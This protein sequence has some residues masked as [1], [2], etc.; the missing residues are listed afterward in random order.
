[1]AID[2]IIVSNMNESQQPIPPS[3]WQQAGQ[4]ITEPPKKSKK[5]LI[6]IIVSIAVLVLI[7]VGAWLVV[8]QQES[9]ETATKDETP[10]EEILSVQETTES[11]RRDLRA[12]YGDME[13]TTV[14]EANLIARDPATKKLVD[15][16]GSG[17]AL[18]SAPIN[19]ANY[20]RESLF[21]NGGFSEI[22]LTDEYMNNDID[23]KAE[24]FVPPTRMFEK[25]NIRCSS[26]IRPQ[27]DATVASV[28]IACSDTETIKET[29]ESTKP[30]YEAYAKYYETRE[31]AERD[32]R[33]N[34][35]VSIADTR[36]GGTEG[37]EVA[38]GGTSIWLN[39]GAE[40]QIYF[41]RTASGQSWQFAPIGGVLVPAC[42]AL[43]DDAQAIRAFA[44]VQCKVGA[45]TK[46][47]GTH[48]AI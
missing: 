37:F 15:A 23:T 27:A 6:A 10:K 31:D 32:R 26:T 22:D 44:D 11:L 40:E 30:F 36:A 46:T 3:I 29:G 38:Q 41:Y 18:S 1:M 13:A 43:L 25:R 21:T 35:V 16:K 24:D 39:N 42:D 20:A 19:L 17:F 5:P 8:S 34:M 9:S 7:G 45:N 47:F 4:P 28:R 12:A 2:A 33:I 48:F 14:Q